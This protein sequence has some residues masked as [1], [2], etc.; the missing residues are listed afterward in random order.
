V[1]IIIRITLVFVLIQFL[2]VLGAMVVALL[3][4]RPELPLLGRESNHEALIRRFAGVIGLLPRGFRS[5]ARVV[6][7]VRRK[8]V[9]PLHH[10]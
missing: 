8:L 10:A 9:L 3:L 1:N 4:A 7:V 2:V 6:R 5:A